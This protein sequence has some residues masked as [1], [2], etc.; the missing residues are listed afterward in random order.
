MPVIYDQVYFLD[1]MLVSDK[2]APQY[3]NDRPF[4]S[5]KI[6]CIGYGE[7]RTYVRIIDTEEKS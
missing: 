3:I 6:G 1:D 4:P 7:Y 2:I 5:G